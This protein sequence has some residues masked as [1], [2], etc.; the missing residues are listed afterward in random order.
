MNQISQLFKS[1]FSIPPFR[2]LFVLWKALTASW[3]VH[4]EQPVPIAELAK[5]REAASIPSFGFFFLLISA[6]VIA[7][8]GLYA[9]SAAVI[10]GAM[11]VA[12]LM[13]PILSMSFGIV[14]AN[15]KLY[16]RSIATV[17]LGTFVAILTA[18]LISKLLPVEVVRSEI[19]AR[20]APN[21][22][23]LGIAIA[24]GAAGSFSLTRKSIANSIAG[25]AIAVAL[26]PPLCVVGIGLGIGEEL[27]TEIGQ[28]T[29]TDISVAEGAFL[30]FLANLAGITFTAC[31][32]FLSQAYGSLN[33][34]FQSLL[35][36]LLIIAILIV[37]LNNSLREFFLANQVSKEINKIRIENP[38][39]AKRTQT[40]YVHVKLEG[41]TAYIKILTLAPTGLLTDDYLKD[42][43]QQIFDS[44]SSTQNIKAMD[45]DLRIIPVD[46]RHYQSIYNPQKNR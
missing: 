6:T 24:A 18:Y 35:I 11:I 22:I 33:K 8:L 44:I 4:L 41:T 31:V 19:M 2:Q 36:W 40:R 46:I 29:F 10:I 16:K 42:R 45:L 7:T 3:R 14:T 13:N 30:L 34:A 17:F 28:T 9:N 37:P 1:L 20:T 21:L 39:I 5:S 32:V 38:E 12:P 26:V 23:D 25:V 27:I 15:W 43:E